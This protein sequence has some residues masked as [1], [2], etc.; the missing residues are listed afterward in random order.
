M[1]YALKVSP[2]K[3]KYFASPWSPPAWMKTNNNLIHGGFL[4]G[5]PG[6]KYY[7]MFAKYFVK[8]LQ[9]YEKENITFWAITILN[10]PGSGFD[11]FYRWNCLGLDAEMERDFLKM[12]LGPELYKNGYTKDKLSIIIYDDQLTNIT[13]FTETIMSDKQASKFVSGIG[14]HWYHNDNANRNDLDS[15]MK[16][17]SNTFLLAT[18]A[19]AEWKKAKV[20]VHL[21][22]WYWFNRYVEDIIEDLNHFTTGWV[23]WNLALDIRG[24]PNW[25]E[26]FVS[27]P[28]IVNVTGQEYYKQPIFYAMGHFSK[29]LVPGSIRIHF[30]IQT[31][32]LDQQTDLIR[33]TV[34]LRPDNAIVMILLNTNQKSIPVTV[35]DEKRGVFHTILEPQSLINFMWY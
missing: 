2:H 14:F 13:K 35:K 6:G 34:F 32:L 11:P 22:S 10:E 26:N 16:K 33:A 19:C 20:H 7:K 18:E 29:F 9:A 15:L 1:K 25:V 30:S 3:V 24:G 31:T 12:D 23:D 27:S 4:K 21:G 17:Y 28:V 5:H 8:F